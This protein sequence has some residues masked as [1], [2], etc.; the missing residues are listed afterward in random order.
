MA[1]KPVVRGVDST[2]RALARFVKRS[3]SGTARGLRVWGEETMTYAKQSFVPVL[4]G[5]LRGSGTVESKDEGGSPSVELAFGGQ[6]PAGEYAIVVHER[7]IKYLETPANER[8]SRLAST[9]AN[10]IR[11]ETG[12]R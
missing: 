5:N 10:E 4:T 2:K 7:T 3:V 11:K 8:S 1:S 6:A 9:V 12:M